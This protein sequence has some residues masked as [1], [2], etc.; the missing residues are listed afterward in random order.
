M[1]AALAFTVLWGFG[2]TYFLRSFLTTREITPVIHL[3]GAVF[4]G[5]IA[6]MVVQA[7]FVAARRTPLH[8]TVGRAGMM[9]AAAV[10]VV[11]LLV[12]VYATSERTNAWFAMDGWARAD[13]LFSSAS[14][15]M[16]FAMFATAGFLWRRRPDFHKRMMLL[17][18]IAIINAAVARVLDEF[19]WPIVLGPFGFEAPT[20]LYLKVSA[21]VFA[22]GFGNIFVLPFVVALAAYD[23][24]ATGR[25]HRATIVG[26]VSLI[27]FEPVV[28]FMIAQM[29]MYA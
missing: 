7:G 23:L 5:W 9:L 27:L 24:R 18:S 20:G 15:P 3:H 16:L 25:L 6:L 17:A 29:R 4:V 1:S 19:G 26:G 13:A 28:R 8:R 12:P 2:P 14:G 10:V 22:S 11:G 21:G